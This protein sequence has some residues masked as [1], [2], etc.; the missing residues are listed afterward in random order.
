V[1]LPAVRETCQDANARHESADPDLLQGGVAMGHYAS[2][3]L[4]MIREHGLVNRPGPFAMIERLCMTGELDE[5]LAEYYWYSLQDWLE[6]FLRRPIYLPRAPTMDEV[7][8]D[9]IDRLIPL[10]N[11]VERPDVPFGMNIEAPLFAIYA[12]CCG[13]G[14]TIG[15]RRLVLN[16]H[17]Y[18]QT[19]RNP[20]TILVFDRKGHDFTDLA[21]QLGDDCLL[22]DVHGEPLLGLN[23]PAGVPPNVWIQSVVSTFS[24]CFNL[25][26]SGTSLAHALRWLVAVMNPRPSPRLRWPDFRLVLDTIRGLPW[27]RF[28]RRDAYVESLLQMLEGVVH[29]SGNLFCTF[30][31]L[32]IDRDLAK[33]GCHAIISM[34]QIA[35][36]ALR[37]FVVYLL[38][39]QVLLGRVY[40]GERTSRP[41]LLIVIDEA[42]ADVSQAAEYAFSDQLSPIAHVFRQGREFGIGICLGVSSLGPVARHVLN[43]ASYHFMMKM[44]N[45]VCRDEVRRTLDLPPRAD[46]IIPKLDPGEALTRTPDWAEAVL[47]KFDSVPPCRQIPDRFDVLPCIPSRRFEEIP[48]LA[49]AVSSERSAQEKEEHRQKQEQQARLKATARQLM[50]QAAAHPYW[51]VARLYDLM[52][53]ISRDMRVKIREQLI[54]S[55]YARF[56]TV[57]QGSKNQDLIELT[58]QAWTLLGEP[59]IELCGRGKLRHVTWSHWIAMA[60]AQDGHSAQLEFVVPGSSHPVD[61]C[62]ERNGEWHAYEVVVTCE[63]NLINHLLAIF[64]PESPVATATIVAARKMEL[65]QIRKSIVAVPELAAFQDRIHYEPVS[66][67]EDKL[68]PRSERAR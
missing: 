13:A 44:Q 51:P 68:W 15:M 67:F 45:A 27:R 9:G 30:N 35:P 23:N 8:P 41:N 38:V 57:K 17:A 4:R 28:S 33:R 46:G 49:E 53:H 26:F 36:A 11:L 43:S 40:R 29:A 58:A 25:K 14:K 65:K 64:N 20:I 63:S 18:N 3:L 19:A 50:V 37:R 52:D 7:F 16:V 54:E 5:G 22:L 24:A 62:V 34:P 61:V 1:A 12:G 31:G 66:I 6:A 39:S 55:E 59:P 21:S 48:E 42:D 2:L 32:D 10:G 56:E 47:A 60:A